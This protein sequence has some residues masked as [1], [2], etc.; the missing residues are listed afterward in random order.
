MSRRAWAIITLVSLVLGFYCQSIYASVAGS[1]WS[2]AAFHL[3]KPLDFF[4]GIITSATI[5]ASILAGIKLRSSQF[6]R[7]VDSV[8]TVFLTWIIAGLIH[9]SCWILLFK[10]ESGEETFN[11]AT[12][13]V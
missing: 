8:S 9:A 4:F 2:I 3:D 1:K 7:S 13:F 5:M 12:N 10:I 6:G 11:G